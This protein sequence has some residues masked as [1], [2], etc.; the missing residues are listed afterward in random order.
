MA[1]RSATTIVTRAP[2]NQEF[3]IY[4]QLDP[5]LENAGTIGDG[6]TADIT[7]EDFLRPRICYYMSR[8]LIAMTNFIS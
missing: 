1:Q 6:H 3:I 4:K 5:R 8:M 2:L 7:E